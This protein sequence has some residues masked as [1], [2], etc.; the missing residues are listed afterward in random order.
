MSTKKK[1]NGNRQQCW[2][3]LKYFNK[4]PIPKKLCSACAK[5]APEGKKCDSQKFLER[6]PYKDSIT[7]FRSINYVGINRIKF[8][9][10]EFLERKYQQEKQQEKEKIFLE[11]KMLNTQIVIDDCNLEKPINKDSYKKVTFDN[12]INL[13][14]QPERLI[15]HK[16][17]KKKLRCKHK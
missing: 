4:D 7:Y 8:T 10:V 13:Y 14:R 6:D 15:K 12:D 9:L 5:Y 3:C 1:T 2:N 16:I 11:N 17:Q